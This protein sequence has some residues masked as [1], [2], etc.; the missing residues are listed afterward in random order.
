MRIII[1][2]A[3]AVGC[4]VGGFLAQAGEEVLLLGRPGN[5]RAIS[6]QGLKIVTPSET[7]AVRLKAVTTVDQIGFSPND[8]IFLCVKAQ[9]TEDALRELES[10]DTTIPLFC[11][12]NGVRN[13]ECA[14]RH[15]SNV[16]G[17]ALRMGVSYLTDGEVVIRRLPPGQLVVGRYPRGTDGLVGAV[18]EK[19][20]SAGFLV[21]LSPDIMP[22]KWG[23]LMINLSNI[24]TA[25]ANA[26]R[27]EVDFIIDAAREELRRILEAACIPWVETNEPG[28]D[29]STHGTGLP[30]KSG[31]DVTAQTSTWQSLF[32]S[33]GTI[34]TE[35]LNGEVVRL[36][37]RLGMQAPINAALLEISQETMNDKDRPGKYAPVELGRILG[38]NRTS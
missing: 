6:D 38:L 26:D 17:V 19:L 24:V 7:Q 14:A 27:S 9:N 23:K 3:G 31:P 18:A 16:Y 8:V 10:V 34:E 11:M 20:R 28:S 12:Q 1:Y 36:A 29:R 32:R 22:H 33:S 35:F 30:S 15:F 25:V 21:A 37:K 2:G 13:E 4:A 5:M